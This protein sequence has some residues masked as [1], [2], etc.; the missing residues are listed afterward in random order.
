MLIK[1]QK[2]KKDEIL[3]S[4]MV[5][6]ICYRE[7]RKDLLSNQ[8]DYLCPETFHLSQTAYNIFICRVAITIHNDATV[9]VFST[10]LFTKHCHCFVYSLWWI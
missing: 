10:T 5:K 7:S 2:H 9:N 4:Y 8:I 6:V 1:I 3:F